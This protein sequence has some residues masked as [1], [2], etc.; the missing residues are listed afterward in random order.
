MKKIIIALL[1]TSILFGYGTQ[2]VKYY[3]MKDNGIEAIIEYP[4]KI[5]AGE[6]FRIKVSMYNNYGYARMGGFTLSFPQLKF[7]DGRVLGGTFDT[8]SSYSPPDKIYSGVKKRNITSKY[9]M[10]EGWENKW[11]KGTKR[12]FSV[13]LRAP[14]GIN[15]L[16]VN[17]RGVLVVGSNKKNSRE[18]IIPQF[19]NYHDQQSYVV[20]RLVIP[21]IQQ[22][23]VPPITTKPERKEK[24]QIQRDIT[25]T[26]FFINEYNLLTNSH[27]VKSCKSIDLIRSGYRSTATIVDQDVVNDLAILKANNKNTN[28][29]KLRSGKGIRIGDEIIVIGYPLGYLLGSSIKLTTGNVSA[30]TGLINDTTNLQLTAPVQPGNSGGPLLDQSG[31]VVGVVVARL[32][33][34]L[35]GRKA[36]NVNLAI[37]S[38][39]AQ[40]FLDTNSIEYQV[41]ESLIKKEVAD[42]A[43]EA[44]NSIVQVVCHQ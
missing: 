18:I 34:D 8:I 36:Q 38:Y 43:D 28:A 25:G 7:L 44:K 17:A 11:N 20:K 14:T 21:L 3:S 9:Y 33:K 29:L 23:Y 1:Y 39:L 6:K 16:L 4:S 41:S 32:D 10:L 37:K 19:G 13:E 40:M 22:R 26:G 27:V 30:L 42:I 12:T 24:K 5:I 31:N 35:S 2:K 15:S